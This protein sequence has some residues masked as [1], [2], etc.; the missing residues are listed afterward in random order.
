[1]RKHHSNWVH[2]TQQQEKKMKKSMT[3]GMV[4]AVVLVSATVASADVMTF[5]NGVSGYSAGQDNFL[6]KIA[7]DENNNNGGLHYQNLGNPRS[8]NVT[9]DN[10]PIWRWDVSALA[11]QYASINSITMVLTSDEDDMRGNIAEA[12]AELYALTPANSAWIEGTSTGQNAA[13]GESSYQSLAQ[14]ATAWAGG[15]GA[16]A[17]GIDYHPGSMYSYT[18]RDHEDGGASGGDIL[19]WVLSPPTGMTLMDLV[20]EWSGNQAN[21]AGMILIGPDLSGANAKSAA[22]FRSGDH[23]TLADHPQLIVD[24]E[25]FAGGIAES[26]ILTAIEVTWFASNSV[27][28][29]AQFTDDLV[30]TNW[31]NLGPIVTGAG[32]TTGVLDSA[33]GVTNRSYRVTF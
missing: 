16:G 12:T 26:E 10:R 18:W 22:Q 6:Q 8:G 7:G 27:G 20:D 31:A 21:N 2:G 1:M 5:Q 33:R 30:D 25:P 3:S 11:G 24:Y 23:A 13:P 9:N 32:G 14:G 28:Y 15:A 19:T 29:Q 17:V 4:A